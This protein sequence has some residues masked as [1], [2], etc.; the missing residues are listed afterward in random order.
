MQTD[1]DVEILTVSVLNGFARELLEQNL[2]GIWVEGEISNLAM[3]SSGHIYFS[4]K[5]NKAQVRCAYFRNRNR[6]SNISLKDGMHI[7]VK[8]NAS[9]Y[10]G[11]GEYQLIIEQLELT[12]DGAL[13]REF[14]L[15]KTKLAAEGLFSIEHKKKLPTA[16]KIIGVITSP[17]GAAIRDVLSVLKRRYPIATVVIYPCQVQGASAASQITAAIQAANQRKECDVLILTRG[18]GSLEDLWCFNDEMLARAIFSSQ[19]PIITGIGHEID[20]TIA[21]FVSDVRAPT[22]S[23]AAELV[24]PNQQTWLTEFNNFRKRLFTLIQY[25]L[26]QNQLTLNSFRKQ[27]RHPNQMIRELNQ[28]LDFFEQKLIQSIKSQIK[29][30]YSEIRHAERTLNIHNPL[31]KLKRYSENIKQCENQLQKN[32]KLILDNKHSYLKQTVKTLNTVS[33]LATLERGYSITRVEEK[34]QV[35]RSI[36]EIKVGQRLNNLLCDGEYSCIVENVHKTAKKVF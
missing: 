9:L 10:E 30:D 28:S 1:L 14:E 7:L 24:S 6:L 25:Y 19:L 27:L 16:P 4:L 21:D 23:A 11:R 2:F 17:T 5:D 35:I 33:P 29:N 3:P 18:G 20:F 31:N 32:L 15:L 22:P 34:M 26:N 8:A 36:N 12:G 13:R